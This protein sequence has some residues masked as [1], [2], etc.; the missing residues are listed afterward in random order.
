[1]RIL[2]Q[3]EGY[4]VDVR[5]CELLGGW[6]KCA[7]VPARHALTS[8]VTCLAGLGYSTAERHCCTAA[9]RGGGSCSRGKRVVGVRLCVL[10][11][12]Y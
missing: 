1:M 4:W 11:E 6:E 12:S 3:E 5:M 7:S 8:D 2:L 9:A 10:T